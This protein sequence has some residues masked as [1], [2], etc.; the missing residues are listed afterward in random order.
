MPE[1]LKLIFALT[2]NGAKRGVGVY[3]AGDEFL[4]TA[5]IA[6]ALGLPGLAVDVRLLETAFADVDLRVDVPGQ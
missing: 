6:E 4:P 1:H 3:G 2:T 5:C